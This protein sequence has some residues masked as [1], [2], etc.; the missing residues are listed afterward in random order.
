MFRI[1]DGIKK[2]NANYCRSLILFTL[3]LASLLSFAAGAPAV[4]MNG[5]E[6]AESAVAVA[7]SAGGG[8]VVQSMQTFTFSNNIPVAPAVL[9]SSVKTLAAGGSL[10]VT[11]QETTNNQAVKMRVINSS[12]TVL[13]NWKTVAKGTTA[14]LYTSPKMVDAYVQLQSSQSYVMRAVGVWTF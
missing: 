1:R 2:P 3:V 10:K 11:L 6:A 14:T 7:G 9:K 5:D 13:A 8:V 12:G 4:E